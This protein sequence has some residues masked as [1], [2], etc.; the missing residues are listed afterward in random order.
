MGQTVYSEDQGPFTLEMARNLER[1]TEQLHCNLKDN[2][3]I[4]FGEYTVKDYDTKI[5]L[6]H[7]PEEHNHM[8]DNYAREREKE[9]NL[10]MED[11]IVK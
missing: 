3:L 1:S 4:R 8:Q 5:P 10:T 7:V 11:R 9:G 2:N 6:L